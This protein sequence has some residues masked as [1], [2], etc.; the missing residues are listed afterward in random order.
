MNN[1]SGLEETA[2]SHIETYFET[3]LVKP[4]YGMIHQRAL[5]LTR[6]FQDAE[7]LTQ[8]TFLNAFLAL[9]KGQFD[10]KNPKS[11]LMQIVRNNYLNSYRSYKRYSTA[12]DS[13]T[14][15]SP[16]FQMPECLFY[17]PEG[18]LGQKIA[19]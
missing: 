1:L 15:I 6:N 3:K 13:L 9:K 2:M 4:Y 7:D 14:Y 12:I 11:W 19:C 16:F 18:R 17:I 8:Q 5:S 10:G